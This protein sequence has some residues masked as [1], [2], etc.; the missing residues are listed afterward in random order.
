MS[1]EGKIGGKLEGGYKHKIPKKYKINNYLLLS[2]FTGLKEG[3]KPDQGAPVGENNSGHSSAPC[4]HRSSD[5][6]RRAHSHPVTPVKR[7]STHRRHDS[8]VL[9]PEFPPSAELK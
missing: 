9:I 7:L 6:N 5:Q 8:L 4:S 3:E 2:L 1:G